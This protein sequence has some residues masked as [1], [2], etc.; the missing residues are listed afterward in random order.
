MGS[1]QSSVISDQLTA[2]CPAS[3]LT[4]ILLGLALSIAAPA[5]GWGQAEQ[6]EEQDDDSNAQD[7]PAWEQYAFDLPYAAGEDQL[8]F[9]D[10]ALQGQ[11]F[12]LFFWI[13]D[14]PLCELQLPFVEQLQQQAGEYD[15]PLRIV[16]ICIDM[17]PR[18]CLPY[19]EEK[20]ISFEVLIDPHARRT[21]RPYNIEDLGTP[22]TYVFDEAG[23][24]AG[25]LT[26]Y[27]S[28]Y[29]ELVLEML[30]ITLPEAA[31]SG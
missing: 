24:L 5:L 1:Y 7:N 21:G 25:T 13:T 31:E 10:L 22:L 2:H 9:V 26:G 20:G 19:V 14:C 4:A 29:A 3:S 18:R 8:A 28:A 23:E 17:D 11:P 15:L 6:K 12:I 30:D 16:S 27:R